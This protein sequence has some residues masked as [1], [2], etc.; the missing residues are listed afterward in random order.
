MHETKEEM[1]KYQFRASV[2]S[3][4]SPT[5]AGTANF[6]GAQNPRPA[7][8][9]PAP[10][11]SGQAPYPAPYPTIPSTANPRAAPIQSQPPSPHVPS[12]GLVAPGQRV[13]PAPASATGG[14]E[15]RGYSPK[16]EWAPAAP[17]AVPATVGVGVPKAGRGSFG[18]ALAAG[19]APVP[20]AA[21]LPFNAAAQGRTA[22]LAPVAQ[23]GA[24]SAGVNGFR[25]G[26]QIVGQAGRFDGGYVS[27]GVGA[28]DPRS[29][30]YQGDATVS[31]PQ[32]P[33]PPFVPE[34]AA[35]AAPS[36]SQPAGYWAGVSSVAEGVN[37]GPLPPAQQTYAGLPQQQQQQRPRFPLQRSGSAGPQLAGWAHVSPQLDVAARGASP[38]ASDVAAASV[39]AA[40]ARP[41]SGGAQTGAWGGRAP[42]AWDVSAGRGTAGSAQASVAKE[43]GVQQTPASA[44]DAGLSAEER[45]LQEALEASKQAELERQQDEMEAAAAMNV[46]GLCRKRGA[47]TK[48]TIC[49]RP[50]VLVSPYSFYTETWFRM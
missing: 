35:A 19:D 24:Y 38:A 11:P 44:R 27:T 43:C 9:V 4:P 30:I 10:G 17:V 33:T 39:G 28:T 5:L 37:L 47:L 15:I 7:N 13:S 50:L 40:Q 1:L 36:T 23:G 20:E 45:E 42:V 31:Y 3:T 21:S 25:H 14:I 2:P 34:A 16:A 32:R 29:T 41:V 8:P 12:P 18:I 46:G 22:A 6:S 49:T 48:R 26:V